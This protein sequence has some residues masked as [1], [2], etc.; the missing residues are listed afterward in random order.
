MGDIVPLKSWWVVFAFSFSP[1]W[2]RQQG[3]LAG[4]ALRHAGR[5]PIG[6]KQY[7]RLQIVCNI[8]RVG[9]PLEPLSLDKEL[10]RG[11]AKTG[12]LQCALEDAAQRRD[13]S[14]AQNWGSGSSQTT[15]PLGMGRGLQAIWTT[16]HTVNPSLWATEQGETRWVFNIPGL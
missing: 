10:H 1:Q 4:P 5:F 15:K 14:A 8:H 7:L 16:F 3:H 6:T 11:D 2:H 13:A 9:C 12:Q